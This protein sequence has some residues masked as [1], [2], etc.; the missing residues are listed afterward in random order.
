MELQQYIHAFYSINYEQPVW[1]YV[2]APLALIIAFS[3]S[4]SFNNLLQKLKFNYIYKH[5]Y[6][7]SLFKLTANQDGNLRKTNILSGKILYIVIIF[8]LST[9]LSSPYYKGEKLPEP[10]D[11]REIVF[12]IDNAVSMMLKDYFIDEIRV[13]RLTMVK[14]VLL[15]F[16]NKLAG[17]RISLV[18]FSEEAHTLL[19]FTTD[20]NL[21]K[22][23]IPRIE[24]TLT[25]RTSNP[26]KAL[27]YT[28]NSLHNNF[29]SNS[30]TKPSIVLITDV[31]RPP[32]DLDPVVIAKYVKKQKY[33][34]YVIAV[35]ASTY[36]KE[37][38]ES[39]SLIY[40]PASFERLKM[41][42][43]AADGKFFWAKSTNSLSSMIQDILKR[44]KSKV[45]VE[46]K[47]IKVP[48]FQWPLAF[49]LLLI[50]SHFLL[51]S[52]QLRKTNA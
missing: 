5:T 25:G 7:H 13:D 20:T 43:Q 16:A 37:D 41:I 47:F 51:S 30:S 48:L 26:Q 23:T 1:F 33:Q 44:K 32:R 14:S 3:D 36:K 19:P 45:Q 4:F 10:P 34:L 40:H 15:N 17:N 18:T 28:L 50:L 39:S 49:A 38:I 29:A 11:N 21:I 12:L 2:F 22:E 24:A 52:I 27:L 35:G 46:S 6:Y 9:T 8:L 42:A 31:L